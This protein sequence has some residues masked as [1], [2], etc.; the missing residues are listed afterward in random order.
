MDVP[1]LLGDDEEPRGPPAEPGVGQGERGAVQ[2][3]P[4]P[5]AELAPIKHVGQLFRTRLPHLVPPQRQLHRR[6]R[7]VAAII[8]RQRPV[9]VPLRVPSALPRDNSANEK[10]CAQHLSFDCFRKLDFLCQIVPFS[11]FTI[12]S[13]QMDSVAQLRTLLSQ[14]GA[15]LTADE[16]LSF[17]E[18]CRSLLSACSE[19]ITTEISLKVKWHPRSRYFLLID[20]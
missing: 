6:R 12:S 19:K 17:T 5:R 20:C 9:R 10:S 16:R 4:E 11:Q 18:S 14:A 7:G 1:R 8:T 2:R 15:N 3:G 13:F